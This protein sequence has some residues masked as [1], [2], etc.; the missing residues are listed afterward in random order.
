M[1][2]REDNGEGRGRLAVYPGDEA[3]RAHRLADKA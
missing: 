1:Q 2:I 3:L